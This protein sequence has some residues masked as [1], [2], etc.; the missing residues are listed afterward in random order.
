MRGTLFEYASAGL[1]PGRV[2]SGG[3]EK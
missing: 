1:A 2:V 3:T